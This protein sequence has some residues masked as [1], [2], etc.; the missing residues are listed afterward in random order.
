M[1]RTTLWI[2]ACAGFGVI[3]WLLTSSPDISSGYPRSECRSVLSTEWSPATGSLEDG[4]ET[5]CAS[6]QTRRVGW[7]VLV[8]VPTVAF[9]A[10]GMRKWSA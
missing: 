10:G 8:A 2:L 5:T 7:S 4:V 1:I 6:F 9:A 3:L